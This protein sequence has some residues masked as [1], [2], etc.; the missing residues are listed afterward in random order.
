[1]LVGR[2][3]E[4]AVI[5]ATLDSARGGRSAALCLVGDPG[6]GKSTLLQAAQTAGAD[7]RRLTTVGIESELTL[8]HAGLGDVLSD[9][10]EYLGDLPRAQRS[11]VE[12]ALG[13]A[14]S[15]STG[16]PDPYLVAVGTLSLLAAAAE[17]GPVL[18]IVDDFQ[19]VD[20]ESR[21]AIAF[22]AR[23]LQ[24]DRVAFVLARRPGVTPASPTE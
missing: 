17:Q 19:W 10:A 15:D 6:I 21:R 2:D 8:G 5:I 11:A 7:F 18:V 14:T 24:H 9:A 20:R 23:R 3:T 22:A 12:V 1:M 4:L 13:R 16:G